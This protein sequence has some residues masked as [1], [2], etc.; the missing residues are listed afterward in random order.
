MYFAN[1]SFLTDREKEIYKL[2]QDLGSQKEVAKRL[3]IVDSAVT[4]ALKSIR[5]KVMKLM[6]TVE[7]CLEL[8]L[9][10]KED[11][12]MILEKSEG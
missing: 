3:G 7:E 10:T 12:Q 1:L 9:I 11:L 6:N 4:S 8:G 5:L 2:V